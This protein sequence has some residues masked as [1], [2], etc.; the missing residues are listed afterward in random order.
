MNN[1]PKVIAIVALLLA[2]GASIAW[3][4]RPIEAPPSPPAADT[5]SSPEVT[6]TTS[7]N[8]VAY[9]SPDEY[10][11]SRGKVILDSSG[12]TKLNTLL[13]P[14]LPQTQTGQYRQHAGYVGPETC[15]EC[16]QEYF[17][18]FIETA[19]YHT[20]SR[21]TRDT[22]KGSFA[23]GKN[24]LLTA[25]PSL[26]FEMFEDDQQL[27]QRVV[28]RSSK[29]A[30]DNSEQMQEN[31]SEFPFSIVTGSGKVGQTYLYW[32]SDFLYQLHASYLTNL[33][34][35]VN[36]PGYYDGT[37][38]FARPVLPLCL[39]CHTTKV[40]NLPDTLQYDRDS[41][42]LGV[43]CEK[44]HGPGAEH[45]AF[46]K[47]N[48]DSN[49]AMGIINPANLTAERQMEV[50]QL[51]HG[52]MPE[53]ILKPP[54]SFRPGDRL[55]DFYKQSDASVLAGIHSNS[56]LPRMRMSKCFTESESLTCI[57]CH[58]PHAHERGQMKL[59]SDRCLSCHQTPDC[60]EFQRKGASIADNCID[61]HM[62]VKT[63]EDIV[64]RSGSQEFSPAMRD[65]YIR[66]LPAPQQDTS[67]AQN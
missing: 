56:Q 37:A 51:C 22:V 48:P 3:L 50:C 4:S 35:W 21:A 64:V 49:D 62:P 17:D 1:L 38:D 10:Y 13:L 63:M 19:H 23:E 59:F 20:S 54:F 65:H 9:L 29:D 58:N 41:M 25:S 14:E 16:H 33:D 24:R 26:R 12:N 31:V 44:C 67:A 61:C 30:A 28:L 32:Q 34:A 53:E 6:S 66:V 47:A 27:F 57:D 40:D 15:Q 2:G 36:S 42:I 45:V 55:D 8:M 43:T 18:G 7:D 52:G 46:H 60:G 5:L 11:L 39:E